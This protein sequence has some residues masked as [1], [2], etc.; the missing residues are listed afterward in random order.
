MNTNNSPLVS[1]LTPAYQAAA[2]IQETAESVLSQSC[3][4]FEYILIDDAS[5]DETYPLITKLAQRDDRIRPYSNQINQGI[6]ETRNACVKQA[7][8]KYVLWQ[9]A[10]DISLPD[11]IA[12]LVE[13]MEENPEVGI[14]GSYMQPFGSSGAGEIK[15]YPT[16]DVE[17]RKSIFKIS[18]VSQPTAILRRECFEKV[19]IYNSRYINTEDLDMTFR[20]GMQYELG[21]VPKVLLK[22]R[23]HEQSTTS[24]NMR[25]MLRDTVTIRSAYAKLGAYTVTPADRL[26]MI[27]TRLALLLP[28]QAVPILF[29]LFRKPITTA[30]GAKRVT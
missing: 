17:M 27:A 13:F 16:S 22:Y 1:V 23:L 18:V 10:D 4:D 25:A 19:G 26:A 3:P 12:D 15:T 6:A 30:N 28:T 14:C 20:I 8:G 21:N 2:F 11:R 24:K 9:D 7:R 29:N 5:R